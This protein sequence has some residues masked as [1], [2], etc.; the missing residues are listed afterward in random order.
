[1]I[2]RTMTGSGASDGPLREDDRKGRDEDDSWGDLTVDPKPG[3]SPR[4]PSRARESAADREPDSG[5]K[6]RGLRLLIVDSSLERTEAA[7]TTLEELGVQVAAGGP[8]ESG[9]LRALEIQ[10]DVVLSDL[11]TPGEPG[12]WLFQRF[13]RQPLLRWVPVL[14]MRWWEDQEGGGL[15]VLLSRVTER[16]GEVLAPIRVIEERFA[17]GRAL[18]DRVEVTGIPALLK[19]LARSGADGVL[20]VNDSWNV[21]EVGL[22][23]GEV[24]GVRRR[25]VDGGTDAGPEAFVQLLLC[26]AGRWSFRATDSAPRERN[27]QGNLAHAMDAAGGLL[28]SLLGPAA[29]IGPDSSAQI[30]IRREVLRDVASSLPSSSRQLVEALA[31]GISPSEIDGLVRSPAELVAAERAVLSLMRCGAVR[32]FAESVDEKR[33]DEDERAARSMAYLLTTIAQDHRAPAADERPEQE[34]AGAAGKSNAA[35]KGF[36]QVSKVTAERVAL[37]ARESMNVPG[38]NVRPQVGRIDLTPA[39]S[40]KLQFEAG[41][42]T[43]VLEP[44][45][46]AWAAGMRSSTVDSEP[47]ATPGAVMLHDSL[48]PAPPA[49]AEDKSRR[50]MWLALALA[51]V[52]GGLLVIGLIIIGGESPD[53]P[54]RVEDP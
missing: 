15:R 47:G 30:G 13:R 14:L 38:A 24:T 22:K 19:L 18:A 43:P 40:V 54:A 45:S 4:R 12:W 50:Q 5:L 29:T 21:F 23:A 3:S 9:Y 20:S 25:G 17:A 39:D 1:M 36:Y 10:P 28:A 32:P 27:M 31:G 26:D 11:T 46:A 33:G 6:L 2:C 8:D 41:T 35:G 48:V 34:D 37:K 52:L 51:L 53:P 7:Q 44:E 16:M 42:P 49:T